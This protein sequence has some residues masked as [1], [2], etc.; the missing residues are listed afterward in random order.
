MNSAALLWNR[1]KRT[2]LDKVCLWALVVVFSVVV[3][4]WFL[5][6]SAIWWAIGLL[7]LSAMVFV[8]EEVILRWMFFISLISGIVWLL[9]KL[10]LDIDL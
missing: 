4:V 6:S 2:V 5:W 10:V 9:F 1:P 8:G 7:I 3:A